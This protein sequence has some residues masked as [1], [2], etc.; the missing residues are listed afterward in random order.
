MLG[1]QSVLVTLG[2]V[3]IGVAILFTTLVS[4]SEEFNFDDSEAPRKWVNASESS[5]QYIYRGSRFAYEPSILLNQMAKS[6]GGRWH[7]EK[8]ANYRYPTSPNTFPALFERVQSGQKPLCHENGFVEAV[9]FISRVEQPTHRITLFLNVYR[10]A[11]RI[12]IFF[13]GQDPKS[14]LTAQ[15]F[16]QD[17]LIEEKNN[18]RYRGSV[19]ELNPHGLLSYVQGIENY[20]YTWDSIILD[21]SLKAEVQDTIEYFVRNY[22]YDRW[23]D[24][25]LP[26]AR[27]VILYGPPGTG[28]SL[29]SKILMSQIMNNAYG[30]KVTYIQVSSRHLN[31]GGVLHDI[32]NIARALSPT[33]VFI[34][35]IDLIA[36]LGRQHREEIKN[37]LLQALNGVE[38]LYGVLT[39]ATTNLFGEL[40]PALKRSQRLGFHFAIQEP[41]FPEREK[42]FGL[43]L[44]KYG[45]NGLDIRGYASRTDGWTGADI[46]ELVQLAGELAIGEKS[47][48]G[49]QIFLT[50]QH[51]QKAIELRNRLKKVR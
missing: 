2:K 45:N 31:Y 21:G 5:G 34:E 25:G 38:P 4:H 30:R 13:N 29:V 22:D 19:L 9:Y 50:D 16:Y 39:I 47:I 17:Y 49:D 43:F 1:K 36:G 41:Q 44:Q 35:D 11:G 10:G 26:L 51:L 15:D 8:I 27:G 7:F 32:Y 3:W 28:K 24:L 40:D 46:Q 20:N 14:A 37:E 12:L 23:K 18:S 42:L 33:I 6:S 48:H